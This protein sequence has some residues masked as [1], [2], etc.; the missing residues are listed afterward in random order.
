MVKSFNSGKRKKEIAQG[1]LVENPD[2]FH[3]NVTVP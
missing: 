3:C 2:A 1:S